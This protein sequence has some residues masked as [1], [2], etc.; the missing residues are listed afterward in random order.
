MPGGIPVAVPWDE[1]E[2]FRGHVIA[3]GMSNWLL[4]SV[5]NWLSHGEYVLT[6]I[7]V[8]QGE[9]VEPQQPLPPLGERC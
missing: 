5:S 2:R 8:R 3:Y 7:I 6:W 4:A 9:F 1:D